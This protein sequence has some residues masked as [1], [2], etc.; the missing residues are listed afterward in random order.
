MVKFCYIILDIDRYFVIGFLLYIDKVCFWFLGREF[1][2]VYVF[3]VVNFYI[4]FV[5]ILIFMLFRLDEVV[6][7]MLQ[8]YVIERQVRKYII[9]LRYRKIGEKIYNSITIKIG[10][11]VIGL[12]YRKM[13]G[14]IVVLRYRNIGIKRIFKILCYSISLGDDRENM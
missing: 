13:D 3:S 7:S 2:E 11:Y 5:Q 8:Y 10:E 12:C 6:K 14:Y 9:V 4:F 1:V